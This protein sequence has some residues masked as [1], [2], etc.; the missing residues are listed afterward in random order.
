MY[1][2]VDYLRWSY[3]KLKSDLTITNLQNVVFS[4]FERDKYADVGKN[5]R[6][7][8][9]TSGRNISLCFCCIAIVHFKEQ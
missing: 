1:V 7:L 8:T 6:F 3:V 2:A 5:T 9:K 4:V